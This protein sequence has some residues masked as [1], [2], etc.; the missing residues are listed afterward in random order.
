MLLFEHGVSAEDFF[1]YHFYEKKRRERA[2]FVTLAQS[3]KII[4]LL[5]RNCKRELVENK[6]IFGKKFCD[7]LERNQISSTGLSYDDFK[8]FYFQEKRIIVKPSFG[9]NGDGIFIVEENADENR[10]KWLS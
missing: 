3:Q 2:E 6:S 1:V 8:N 5:N 10:L 7:L 9:C 4:K